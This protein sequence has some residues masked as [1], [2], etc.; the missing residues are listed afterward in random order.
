MSKK[1]KKKPASMLVLPKKPMPQRVAVMRAIQALKPKVERCYLRLVRK[2]PGISGIVVVEFGMDWEKV[3]GFIY[4]TKAIEPPFI[5]G[6][7]TT[8]LKKEA[9]DLSFKLPK[10]LNRET[11]PKVVVFPFS[12][13]KP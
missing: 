10:G 3:E 9:L 6:A 13:S 5:P 2:Y 8:C 11:K 1:P 7:F 4:G 12:F